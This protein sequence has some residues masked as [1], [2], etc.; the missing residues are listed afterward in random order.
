[1]RPYS[2]T[3]F[4]DSDDS[5]IYCHIG[6]SST[7]NDDPYPITLY[8]NSDISNTYSHPDIVF[9]LASKADLINFKNSVIQAFEALERKSTAKEEENAF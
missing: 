9:H 5:K 4:C 8:I 2:S 1:M 7:D 6:N 3:Y